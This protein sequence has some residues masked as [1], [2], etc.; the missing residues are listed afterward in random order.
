MPAYAIGHLHN[1][2]LHSDVF[3]YLERIQ[4]TLDP[5]GG[6]FIVHGGELDVRE[7]EWPGAAVVIEFPSMADARAWYDSPAYQ[8]I[9]ELRNS[10]ITTDAIL[11]EGVEPDHSSAEMAADLRALAAS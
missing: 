8:E 9:L 5:F 3:E 10:H 7:G 4:Y 11:V 6:R 2:R 1:P